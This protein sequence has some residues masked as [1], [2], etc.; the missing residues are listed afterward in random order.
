MSYR[1]ELEKENFKFSASHFTIFAADRGERLHGHN[2]YAN[3]EICLS[4][5]DPELG[6]AFDFNLVKPMIRE[7]TE[8]L[9]EFV[10]VPA[11][12]PFL[13]VE[14]ASGQVSV[15][16]GEKQYS[17]PSDDTRLLPLV[18]ISSEELARY[19]AESLLQKLKPHTDAL[20]RI[21]KFSVGVQESRGQTVVYQIDLSRGPTR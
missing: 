11:N 13:K 17:F 2:Y 20:G 1:I 12:S 18:N 4:S 15:R 8:E 7:I 6:L 9:D 19:I 16:F 3:C 10:L 14:K 21:E 5:V